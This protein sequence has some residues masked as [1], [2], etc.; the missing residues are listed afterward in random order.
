M[1]PSEEIS[2][3]AGS[4]SE[5]AMVNTASRYFYDV[6]QTTEDLVNAGIAYM[7]LPGTAVQMVVVA[8]IIVLAA[9]IA[10]VIALKL[11]KADTDETQAP[12]TMRVVLNKA[13]SFTAPILAMLMLLP[14]S[15]LSTAFYGDA[16]TVE[17]AFR[18]V[19]VWLLWT[20]VR[21]FVASPVVRSIGSWILVPAALLHIFN[22]LGSVITLLESAS[23]D[24]GDI[25][26][27]AYTLVKALV[28]FSIIFW[29]GRF[30]SQAGTEYIRR[31]NSLNVSTKEL[32][33]KLFD[34]GLYVLMF[35]FALDLIGIDLT[36]LAVF[37]GALGVGLGFGLQKIA[38]NF[39]S[40][41]ILL[42]ER[43][44][45][46]GNLVEMDNGIYGF[47]RK[48]GAR[49]SIIETFDGR[50]VMVP[51]EDFIT[52]RVSNLTHSSS[53]GRVD[54]PVGVAYGTDL[55]LARKVM[56]DAVNSYEKTL[57]EK[58]VEANCLLREFGDSSVNFLLVFWMED[59]KEG[60]WPAQSDVMFLVWN[61][62]KEHD[63]EIP[64][65]QRD[66][67]IRSGALELKSSR[68]PDGSE[69]T[70]NDGA[71]TSKTDDDNTAEKEAA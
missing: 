62:L 18:L 8:L 34:I 27:S 55:E 54:I 20:A 67:H 41:I 22:E 56:L 32:M 7:Q 21:A 24:F 1:S 69:P 64:F 19:T 44:V 45:T 11:K 9:F 5:G 49:A 57:K 36:A 13:S 60:K 70:T 4:A 39:I 66:L 28:F 50:E 31:T 3:T 35:V 14:A 71:E 51:N 53:R 61:A 65:P 16:S 42:S 38:S 46:I 17:T 6:L 15:K 63:I 48:L 30:L 47:M 2:N 29:F 68:L 26:V 33:I 52:S 59:V 12:S 10:K 40:G 25:E 37:S 58:G 43:S 23:F